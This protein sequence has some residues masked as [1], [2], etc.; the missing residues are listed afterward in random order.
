MAP[1][2]VAGSARMRFATSLAMRPCSGRPRAPSTQY[3]KAM[4]HLGPMVS[5][6]RIAAIW[7]KA[8]LVWRVRFTEWSTGGHL[9]HRCFEGMRDDKDG[10]EI[11]RE[12]QC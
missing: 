3:R 10:Q 8:L 7:L 12:F 4:A 11:V 6:E 9:R 2:W 5:S 1:R